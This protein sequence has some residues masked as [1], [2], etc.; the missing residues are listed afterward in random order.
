MGYFDADVRVYFAVLGPLY[1]ISEPNS[2]S[3]YLIIVWDI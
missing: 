1:V 2:C 3:I